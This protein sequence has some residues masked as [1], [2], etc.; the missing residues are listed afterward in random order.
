MQA[1]ILIVFRYYSTASSVDNLED[2]LGS[3]T[4]KSGVNIMAELAPSQG[5]RKNL[6]SP[7]PTPYPGYISNEGSHDTTGRRNVNGAS[8]DLEVI[9]YPSGQLLKGSDPDSPP[10]STI[11]PVLE[12][13]LLHHYY[14]G[15]DTLP[16]YVLAKSKRRM[17]L[18]VN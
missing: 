8:G 9:V 4:P 13:A 7:T 10:S 12:S 6:L 5:H 18:E 1:Q 17:E 11:G 14:Q 3:L 2:D 15:R 16:Q